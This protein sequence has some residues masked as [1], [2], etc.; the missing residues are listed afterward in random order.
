MENNERKQKGMFQEM[1]L[2]LDES[3]N[4]GKELF[5]R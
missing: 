2:L 1:Y 3:L 4:D 5:L